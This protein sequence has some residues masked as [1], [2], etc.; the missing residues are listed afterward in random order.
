MKLPILKPKEIIRKLQRRDFII[1]H[2]TG[3]HIILI[4]PVL[5]RRVTVAYHNKDI[6]KK[7]MKNII[8]QAGLTIRRIRRNIKI[9]IF[10]DFLYGF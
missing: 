1:D 3:S 6:K 10:R 8:D 2:Q 4:H 9:P 7:T 5:K